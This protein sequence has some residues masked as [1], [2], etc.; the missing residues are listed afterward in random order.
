MYSASAETI[1]IIMLNEILH[2]SYFLQLSLG[3][4]Y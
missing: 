4:I 3:L 2:F 1:K